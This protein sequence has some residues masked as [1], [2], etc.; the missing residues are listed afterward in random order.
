MAARPLLA[1]PRLA[2]RDSEDERARRNRRDR[3][4]DRRRPRVAHHWPVR[5]CPA[6]LA[7]MASG[8]R[9]VLPLLRGEA[10]RWPRPA[11]GALVQ[12]SSRGWRPPG[13]CADR[14]VGSPAAA[15]ARVL[16][17]VAGLR[18]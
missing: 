8:A 9:A 11:V 4:S 2:G 12:H 6:A 14:L 5:R 1:W 15:R 7:R 3:G 16:G 13:Q 17:L 10:T 18:G